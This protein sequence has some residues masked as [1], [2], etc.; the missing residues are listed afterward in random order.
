MVENPETNEIKRHWKVRKIYNIGKPTQKS[1]H[2]RREFSV[3][4][5][6]ESNKK[7]KWAYFLEQW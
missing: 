4:R 6:R 1:R 3:V 2:W 7:G 5:K